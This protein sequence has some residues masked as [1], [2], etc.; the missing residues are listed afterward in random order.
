MKIENKYNFN[1][2]QTGPMLFFVGK[3]TTM[4]EMLQNCTNVIYSI[5]IDASKCHFLASYG[6]LM[7]CEMNSGEL[8]HFWFSR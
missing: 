5:K 7:A 3:T 4:E 2:N 6:L 8:E 1:T